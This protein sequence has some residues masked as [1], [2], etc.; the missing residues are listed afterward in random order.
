MRVKPRRCGP[1][2]PHSPDAGHPRP[3]A[4]VPTDAHKLRLDYSTGLF[5]GERVVIDLTG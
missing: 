2:P 3:C 5:L 1:P 4:E